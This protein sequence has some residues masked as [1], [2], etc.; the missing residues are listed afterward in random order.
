MYRK[1]KKDKA[2]NSLPLRDL[3]IFIFNLWFEIK[4]KRKL[5]ISELPKKTQI[6]FGKYVLA[7]VDWRDKYKPRYS[8]AFVYYAA[9]RDY[10]L[11]ADKRSSL[12]VDARQ[13]GRDICVAGCYRSDI[14]SHPNL[15][16][17]CNLSDESKMLISGVVK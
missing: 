3:N 15:C 1:K 9:L 8:D 11:V 17:K 5:S 13:I 7:L 2:I 14:L 6:T 16:A 12:C 10:N 4:Y